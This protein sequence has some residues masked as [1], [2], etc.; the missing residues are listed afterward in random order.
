MEIYRVRD[1]Q[2]A[3]QCQRCHVVA[4]W[5]PSEAEALAIA[6]KRGWDFDPYPLCMRCWDEERGPR[7]NFEAA[8][9]RGGFP[10]EPF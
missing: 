4:G 9:E 2:Y 8:A 1:G 7:L 6:R 10:G 5:A 3:V